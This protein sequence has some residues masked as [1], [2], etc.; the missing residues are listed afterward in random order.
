[1]G[2]DR[3][4]SRVPRRTASAGEVGALR[5]VDLQVEL[6][7]A[8][9]IAA[10]AHCS[11]PGVHSD[12]APWGEGSQIGVV[13]LQVAVEDEVAGTTRVGAHQP[14]VAAIDISPGV[15]AIDIRP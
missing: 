3:G 10:V 7:V 1:M 12:W 6:W 11:N 8:G 14:D 5:V 4:Q 15:V 13:A 2:G 9:R